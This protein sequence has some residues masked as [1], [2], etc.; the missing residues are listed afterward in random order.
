MLLFFNSNKKS[1]QQG[2]TYDL[3]DWQT[4]FFK[5]PGRK[6]LSVNKKVIYN[7]STLPE[8]GK[9]GIKGM[10]SMAR[11]KSGDHS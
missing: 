10:F 9:A 6:F 11:I 7:H 3:K 4:I 1:N 8:Q 2:A 5:G